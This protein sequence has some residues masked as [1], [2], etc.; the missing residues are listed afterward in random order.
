MKFDTLWEG[1][2]RLGDW[3]RY[4]QEEA[5]VIFSSSVATIY[6]TVLVCVYIAFTLTKLV[7]FPLFREFL[8]AN[9]F[10]IYLFLISDLYFVFVV[11]QVTNINVV[12]L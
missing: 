11:Y 4:W 12:G 5:L 1:W 9:G 7:K 3:V 2:T 10:F 6:A 8:E